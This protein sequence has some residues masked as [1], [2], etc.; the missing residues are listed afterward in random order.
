MSML[1]VASSSAQTALVNAVSIYSRTLCT[2]VMLRIADNIIS[3]E[4]VECLLRS[5]IDVLMSTPRHLWNKVT[6]RGDNNHLFRPMVDCC[7]AHIPYLW[8]TILDITEIA[9]CM[10]VNLPIFAKEFASGTLSGAHVK[11]IFMECVNKTKDMTF[12]I[13]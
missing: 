2:V 8:S 12:R 1:V 4:F 13:E 3:L 7:E 11:D 9:S 5:I 6:G 10:S